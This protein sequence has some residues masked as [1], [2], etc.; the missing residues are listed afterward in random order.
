MHLLSTFDKGDCW[1]QAD[2]QCLCAVQLVSV[3]LF[4]PIPGC[5]STCSLVVYLL[6]FAQDFFGYF[7]VVICG[8]IQILVAFFST[9][10][11]NVIGN[12]VGII[13]SSMDILTN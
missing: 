4:L 6:L 3:S 8:C 10:V 7:L 12:L 11:K 13:L 2:F 1:E 9:S 5:F